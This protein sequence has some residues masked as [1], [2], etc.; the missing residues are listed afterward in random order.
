MLAEEELDV[1]MATGMNS[2]YSFYR[3]QIM[4]KSTID[5]LYISLNQKQNSIFLPYPILFT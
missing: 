2:E 5:M 3:R 1:R 4:P